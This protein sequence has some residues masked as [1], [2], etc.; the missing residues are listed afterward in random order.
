MNHSGLGWRLQSELAELFR[1]RIETLLPAAEADL[2][3]ATLPL[4]ARRRTF[5]KTADE[6]L[7]GLTHAYKSVLVALTKR[8]I[9]FRLEQFL[10][11]P[12]IQSLRALAR[13]LAIS[14]RI[15]AP[16]PRGVWR[17]MHFLFR[18]GMRH[19]IV[20]AHL[21]G[22]SLT[23]SAVYRQALLLAFAQPPRLMQWDVERLSAYLA[24]FGERA[25]L[26]GYEQDAAMPGVFVIRSGRDSPGRPLEKSRPEEVA[27]DD[28]VLRCQP[29]VETL[30]SQLQGLDAGTP[31]D[32]LGLPSS[33]GGPVSRDLLRQLVQRWGNIQ[34]RQFSRQRTHSRV[35][36]LVGL[37]DIWNCLVGERRG[38][39]PREGR[40]GWIAANESPGGFSLMHFSG[41]CDPIRVG[42]VV[43][44]RTAD[45][46]HIC[47]VRWVQSENPEHLELG[48]Q[49]IAPNAT[50]VTLAHADTATGGP[51]LLLPEMPALGQAAAILAPCGRMEAGNDYRLD[52]RGLRWAVRSTHLLEHTLSIQMFRF[53]PADPLR[54]QQRL[55]GPEVTTPSGDNIENTATAEGIRPE[56]HDGWPATTV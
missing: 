47:L 32:E 44:V 3:E 4:S 16:H 31:P 26:G 18:F 53:R 27:S 36:L 49:K 2:S 22:T 30:V 38:L 50:P 19:G 45:A 9:T 46:C 40:R 41:T 54:N 6:T 13:R 29:L 35:E 8:T 55:S 37:R 43:A 11:P 5:A 14:H 21:P 39:V 56:N 28:L 48:L 34:S 42:E 17:E 12:L 15:Y 33:A 25:V 7:A 20:N 10:V 23:A 51:A 24:R 52:H 1:Q